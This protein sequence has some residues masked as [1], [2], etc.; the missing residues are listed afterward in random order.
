MRGLLHFEVRPLDLY[1]IVME[2]VWDQAMSDGQ[3]H[4]LTSFTSRRNSCRWNC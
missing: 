3:M 2:Q 1:F 4:R